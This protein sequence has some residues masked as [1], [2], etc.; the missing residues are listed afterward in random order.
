MFSSHSSS[1][2]ITAE[3]LGLPNIEVIDVRS[4]LAAKKITITVK[5]TRGSVL[6]S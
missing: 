6:C 5:N 1:I 3:L 2:N 4:N